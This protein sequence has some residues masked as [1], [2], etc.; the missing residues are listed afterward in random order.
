[1]SWLRVVFVLLCFSLEVCIWVWFGLFIF[2]VACLY[3]FG[4]VSALGRLNVLSMWIL[5]MCL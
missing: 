2:A 4:Y 5:L 1:M 3:V